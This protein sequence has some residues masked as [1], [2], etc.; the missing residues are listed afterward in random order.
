MDMNPEGRLI[1]TIDNG[2]T[3][4]I[5]EIDTQAYLY[6]KKLDSPPGKAKSQR[7]LVEFA[8]LTCR[9]MCQV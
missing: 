8:L 2:G 1:A 9:T 5:S 4:L 3:C 7:L 6:H